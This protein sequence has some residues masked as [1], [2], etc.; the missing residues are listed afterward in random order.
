MARHMRWPTQ[1]NERMLNFLRRHPLGMANDPAKREPGAWP[2]AS[3]RE[4][5]PLPSFMMRIP[6]VARYQSARHPNARL[7]VFKQ[8]QSPDRHAFVFGRRLLPQ[9]TDPGHDDQLALLSAPFVW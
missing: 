6:T 8:R 2:G 7:W 4:R 5:M 3:R 1:W 9:R